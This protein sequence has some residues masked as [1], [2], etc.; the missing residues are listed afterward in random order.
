MR[1]LAFTILLIAGTCAASVPLAAQ[2]Y[3]AQVI[4]AARVVWGLNAPTATF[5]SQI[6]Q[7]SGWRSDAQSPYA[8]GL[9]QF[10]PETATWISGAYQSE[11]GASDPWN[12]SWSIQ[13]LVRYDKHL[14]DKL[15]AATP[16]D[17]MAM[18]L[19]AYNGGLGWVVRDKAKSAANGDSTTRWWGH[20]ER[21]NAG[22][23]AENFRENRDYPRRILLLH[24]PA[25]I[26]AGWGKGICA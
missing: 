4:R 14:Y 22:R 19:S 2:A 9:A 20:V 10:T 23:S 1:W 18:A 25:Y 15:A 8:N 12:P 6:H 7:E 17:R 13:A 24:E 3:R 26:N 21:Y 16:C 5:A 11:L